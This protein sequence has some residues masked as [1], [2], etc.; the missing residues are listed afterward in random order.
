MRKTT[1]SAL[2][3]V[4]LAIVLHNVRF[5]SKLLQQFRRS[6]RGRLNAWYK[7][8]ARVCIKHSS[9]YFLCFVLLIERNSCYATDRRISLIEKCQNN[10]RVFYLMFMCRKCIKGR[11]PVPV[12]WLS[13]L[14]DMLTAALQHAFPLRPPQ[15]TSLELRSEST[16]GCFFRGYT[17]STQTRFLKPFGFGRSIAG[18][19]WE[20]RCVQATR[21]AFFA[22]V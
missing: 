19:V 15:V 1:H 4:W 20:K 12:A 18:I 16:R 9:A 22:S 10:M 5:L 2:P 3:R 14:A 17:L 13:I 7:V 8:A 21:L 11:M 6:R